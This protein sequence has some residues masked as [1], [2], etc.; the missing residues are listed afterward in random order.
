MEATA[1]SQSRVH[2]AP[3]GWCLNSLPP[4]CEKVENV[5]RREQPPPCPSGARLPPPNVGRCH[6]AGG[7]GMTGGGGSEGPLLALAV[8]NTPRCHVARP[9][10]RHMSR[11]APAGTTGRLGRG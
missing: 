11:D 9:Q 1:C 2:V 6:R 4:E 8:T 10:L 5:L 7:G 3:R